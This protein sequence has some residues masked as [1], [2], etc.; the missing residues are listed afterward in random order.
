MKMIVGN[1]FQI[2]CKKI[3]SILVGY[4]GPPAIGLSYKSFGSKRFLICDLEC[5]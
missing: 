2:E 4:L 5:S 1:F 3:L